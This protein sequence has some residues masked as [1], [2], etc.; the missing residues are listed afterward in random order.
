MKRHRLIHTAAACALA[1]VV[2][3]IAPTALS[4]RAEDKWIL[5]DTAALTLTV[6]EGE[7]PVATHADI[8]IGRNGFTRQKVS[9]DQRT[10]LGAYHVSAIR[11]NSRFHRFIAIDYPSLDD[12]R[13]A[14]RSG[15][16]DE[17]SFQAILSAHER[18]QPP[19]ADTPLGG[20]IG[21]HGIGT[22]DAGIHAD[23]H[24]TDGC[25]ALTNEQIDELTP[26]ITLGMTVVIR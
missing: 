5:V 4:L 22:G 2:L 9:R 15:R 19:P 13:D 26:L 10:P 18:G 7:K 16:I 3:G 1:S 20:H 17:A 21:I 23:F 25:I 6:L 8:S 24:W 12:A 14:L 11:N